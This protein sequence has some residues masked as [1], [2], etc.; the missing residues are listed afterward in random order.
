MTKI[1]IQKQKLSKPAVVLAAVKINQLPCKLWH[2]A[3]EIALAS[4]LANSFASQLN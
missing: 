3:I 4:C 1:V 2:K